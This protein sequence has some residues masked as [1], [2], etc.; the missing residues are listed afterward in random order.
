MNLLTREQLEYRKLYV[1]WVPQIFGSCFYYEIETYG[2]GK[3]LEDVLAKYDWFQYQENIKG[4]YANVGGLGIYDG[5]DLMDISDE[6]YK[7]ITEM[8]ISFAEYYDLSD[9][10]EVT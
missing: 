9:T 6:D 8:N 1:W 7:E 10:L 5:E 3:L 4:D 2:Q